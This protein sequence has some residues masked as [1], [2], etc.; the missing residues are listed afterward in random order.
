MMQIILL[1]QA[2]KV[3]KKMLLLKEK[4]AKPQMNL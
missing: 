1:I 3:E 2:M 4:M